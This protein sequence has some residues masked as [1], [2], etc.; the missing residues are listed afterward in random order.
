M[1]V[2]VV[3][4]TGNA[5]GFEDGLCAKIA[6]ATGGTVIDGRGDRLGAAA[7]SASD[8]SVIVVVAH[9]SNTGGTATALDLGLV[10]P[11]APA[12]VTHWLESP[13]VMIQHLAGNR[14][15]F[16]VV[17][18]SCEA[19]STESM[20]STDQAPLCLGSVT[21]ADRICDTHVRMI[22]DIVDLLQCNWPQPDHGT[23]SARI[24]LL[25]N[26]ETPPV[27]LQYFPALH[28]TIEECDD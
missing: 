25:G 8:A 22:A 10:G 21:S 14:L 2:S 20:V 11:S 23:L 19:L 16:F 12:V 18:C 27:A 15:P 28:P 13:T 24:P 17:W 9:G 1:S 7:K 5:R 4:M 26:R 6:E 3:N